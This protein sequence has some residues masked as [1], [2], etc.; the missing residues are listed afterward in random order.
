MWLWNCDDASQR[1]SVIG[2]GNLAWTSMK[3]INKLA[4]KGNNIW[5]YQS[6][7]SFC[8]L[9]C[10]CFERRWRPQ[11][12]LWS[13]WK[14]E[15]FQCSTRSLYVRLAEGFVPLKMDVSFKGTIARKVLQ[16]CQRHSGGVVSVGFSGRIKERNHFPVCKHAQAVIPGWTRHRIAA[17]L[18]TWGGLNIHTVNTETQISQPRSGHIPN[19]VFLFMSNVGTH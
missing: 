19:A 17:P 15:V 2:W 16:L 9:S 10:F 12:F 8:L 11:W 4:R 18:Q 14:R 6:F 7:L 5:E 13:G 3:D 1:G